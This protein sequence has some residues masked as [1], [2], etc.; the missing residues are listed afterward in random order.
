MGQHSDQNWKTTLAGRQS[1]GLGFVTL[2]KSAG[3]AHA[4][5]ANVAPKIAVDTTRMSVTHILVTKSIDL[6]GD[7]VDPGGGDLAAHEANPVVF[8]D[9]RTDYKHPIA[10]AENDS[11]YTVKKSKDGSIVYAETFFIPKDEMSSQV[12]GLIAEDAIRGW[13][14]GFNPQPGGFETIRKSQGRG[15]RGSYHFK[16]W[17][18]LEYSSTPQPVNPD[19][20]TVLVEKGRLGSEV[21]NP[22]ILKSLSAQVISNRAAIVRVPAHP[23]TV[24][25]MAPQQAAP[26]DDSDPNADPYADESGMDQGPQETPTVAALYDAA[27]GVMDLCSGLEQAVAGSEHKGGKAFAASVCAAGQKLAAKIKGKADQIKSE[28][29]GEE[30]DGDESGESKPDGD[31]DDMETDDDGG[32]VTKGGYRPKRWTTGGI[33]KANAGPKKSAIDPVQFE[34]LKTQLLELNKRLSAA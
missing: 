12:F 7:V 15:D 27:Q 20:L 16:K 25:A 32:I 19:A 1:S 34:N 29:A 22:I 13:S 3:G 9:H 23:L 21:L 8:Y 5:I 30:P 11:Q 2:R 14:V 31:D 4:E 28:L 24:K 26:A 17:D 33:A 10:R 6:Q 18:L